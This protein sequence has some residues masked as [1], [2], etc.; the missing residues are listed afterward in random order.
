MLLPSPALDVPSEPP[1]PLE[2]EPPEP[3]PPEPE[4]PGSVTLEDGTTGAVAVDGPPAR[5]ADA[6]PEP[7]AVADTDA[8]CADADVDCAAADRAGADDDAAVAVAVPAAG[9]VAAAGVPGAFGSAGDASSCTSTGCGCDA[10]PAVVVGAT[11]ALCAACAGFQVVSCA[12]CVVRGSA[13]DTA[14]LATAAVA[15]GCTAAEG[16]ALEMS[17]TSRWT[18]ECAV[19]VVTTAADTATAAIFTAAAPLKSDFI[20]ATRE[21]RL[22]PERALPVLRVSAAGCS[23]AVAS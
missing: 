8:D 21:P 4:L 2:P 23:S 1:E 9:V 14:T 7:I 18:T 19:L 16:C 5:G 6:A 13:G 20:A 3:E 22:Q 15:V 12:R 17:R 10:R 11:D